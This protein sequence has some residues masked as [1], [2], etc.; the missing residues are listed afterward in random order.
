MANLIVEILQLHCL[1]LWQIIQ[2]I[3]GLII[4]A[5]RKSVDGEIVL[6]TGAG[7]G[8]GKLMALRFADLGATVLC[9]DVNKE[10]ND[11][12]VQE[13]R[14]KLRDAHGYIFDCSNRDDVY[15]VAARIRA[16]VGEVTILVNN[17]G[18]V[19]GKKFLDTP[20][21]LIQKTFEVNTISHFWTTKAF[22][23][24]MME[25]NHGHIVSVASAAGL[26]GV[27]GLCDYCASKFGALGFQE[28][29]MLE[30]RAQKKTGIHCTTIC[31]YYINTGMFEGTKTKFP[32]LLPIMEPEYVADKIM[33][34]VLCNKEILIVPWILNVAV[35]LK[36]ILPTS[37]YV[38]M[39]DFF[40]F[41]ASMDEFV[42]R[43]KNQ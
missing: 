40:G 22:L 7:S 38:T 43:K 28:S 11:K 31:P 32:L 25:K 29:L 16:E 3:V 39:S 10:A 12:T 36:S 6:I 8:L 41:T 17:A 1:L 23:P 14:G 34:T 35:F 9:C 30:M 24:S 5:R 42:G 18:I 19:S 15:D 33:D 20:D 2:A 26:S 27:N 4:P 13:I 37:S 21:S